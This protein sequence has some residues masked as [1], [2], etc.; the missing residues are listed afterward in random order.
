MKDVLA[1]TM[2]FH[3]IRIG[4]IWPDTLH[5]LAGGKLPS[6]E[7]VGACPRRLR[8]LKQLFY[9]L[10]L[11][12]YI[13]RYNKKRP[14]P[15]F[16]RHGLL[17]LWEELAAWK[18]PYVAPRGI[19]LELRAKTCWTCPLG[20]EPQTRDSGAKRGLSLD[21]ISG[22]S[23]TL[24]V[25][26]CVT[27]LFVGRP[28][29]RINPTTIGQMI[30][31]LPNLRSLDITLGM[32]RHKHRALRRELKSSLALVLETPTLQRLQRLNLALDEHAPLSHSSWTKADPEYPNGD[33]LG[34]AVCRLAQTCLEELH[35]SGPVSPVIFGVDPNHPHH[36]QKQFPRLKKLDIK[37]PIHTYDG[38]WYYNDDPSNVNRFFFHLD[39]LQKYEYGYDYDSDWS[40][41]SD[42]DERHNSTRT[43][44]FIQW[45]RRT[46]DPEMFEP[47]LRALVSATQ[48]M[49]KLC[50][51]KFV[52]RN[53]E[54]ALYDLGIEFAGGGV[55]ANFLYHSLI[56]GPLVA[57]PKWVVMRGLKMKWDLPENIRRM[58]QEQAGGNAAILDS[59][60][61]WMDLALGIGVGM[62]SGIEMQ[63]GFVLTERR[64][65]PP[66]IH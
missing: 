41:A 23:P 47:L 65:F 49:P 12:G 29:H 6:K 61:Y 1:M 45:W 63:G 18:E 20:T 11:P 9:D 4:I 16:F 66:D 32:I 26:P 25:V 52:A 22:S 60:G 5:Y 24:P 38:R 3:S 28:G 21:D 15:T 36:E 34:R 42:T 2:A 62:W 55:Q 53:W 51:L 64:L 27:G 35:Y 57:K 46:V 50:A 17:Q 14:Y 48:R 31:S 43:L 7:T 58:M 30:L 44:K 8:Y 39:E 10:D 59:D 19:T 56:S 54:T 37:F 40:S 33:D 13:V